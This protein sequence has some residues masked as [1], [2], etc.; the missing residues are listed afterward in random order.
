MQIHRL[1]L[2]IVGDITV[3]YSDD[4]ESQLELVADNVSC[5]EQV[6]STF[7]ITQLEKGTSYKGK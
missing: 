3:K 6:K 7:K 4:T 2:F 5:D 1:H